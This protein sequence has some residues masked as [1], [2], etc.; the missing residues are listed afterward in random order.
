MHPP[1]PLAPPPTG[2]TVT[3][4]VPIGRRRAAVAA[5]L[6]LRSGAV[7]SRRGFCRIALAQGVAAALCPQPLAAAERL[8]FERRSPYQSVQV[9]EDERGL[10]S[11]RFGPY[12]ARQSVVRPGDPDHVELAYVRAMPAGLA[13]APGAAR[14]LVVGLGGGSL[15]SLLR[16]RLPAL[17][18]DVVEL[19][20]VVAE[21]ARSHFGVREDASLRVHIGDGRAFIERATERW[22]LVALDAYDARSVPRRLATLEFFRAVRRVLSPGGVAIANIWAPELNPSYGGMLR[23]WRDTFEE[24]WVLDA[25]G[26][27]NRI[28]IGLPVGPA[29]P[30]DEIVRRCAALGERMALRF[31]LA[32]IVRH[33]LRPV[34]TDGDAVPA[35]R[36]ADLPRG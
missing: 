18:I 34:G 23:A 10:R 19:D 16:H 32:A 9:L 29:P 15:P 25:E 4:P 3:V 20:P 17:R 8:L 7:S 30:P 24:T 14:V 11:L 33:G 6:A 26:S 2:A 1:A 12:G 35:L 36:D 13:Y 27:G 31:D 21:V 28:V 5:A 22:D